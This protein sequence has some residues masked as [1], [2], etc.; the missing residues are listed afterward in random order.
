MN[1]AS[2]CDQ[3]CSVAKSAGD[4]IRSESKKFSPSDVELKGRN[5]LV[6]YVDK[7]SEE[8]IVS[9]LD[10]LLP[11]SGFITEED[12]V[13]ASQKEITW[14]ID[15]LDGTTNFVHK[16]P[17]YCISI[18]MLKDGKLSL[19][20]IYELNLDEMFYGYRGGKAMLN[21]KS[22]KVSSTK[23]VA[24][25]LIATG[26]PYTDYSKME[27]YIKIFQHLMLSS[28]GLRRM[29]SAAVDLAYVAC[30]RFDSFYEYGLNAWDVAAGA[31]LVDLAGGK[32]SDFSGG[33]NF[34]FGK[35]IITSNGFT[36]D[37]MLEAIGNIIEKE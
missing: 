28:R 22:I 29:G 19:G 27:P 14:I 15:P 2:L 1:L 7:K 18:G 20:V 36:H 24:D 23:T 16:L 31:F 3:V 26:F 8:M 33:D 10:K 30:G 37:E 6:S 11:G 25:S 17:C 9:A 4:F 5:N 35:E 34:L 13:G 12:T 32:N 21:R